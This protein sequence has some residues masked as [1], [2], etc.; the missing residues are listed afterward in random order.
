M[1]A[2]C[3][4]SST[5][6]FVYLNIMVRIVYTDGT[7][8]SDTLNARNRFLHAS[9]YTNLVATSC[10]Q[11]CRRR[12][13]QVQCTIMRTPVCATKEDKRISDTNVAS[14]AKK[15]DKMNAR[16]ITLPNLEVFLLSLADV[17][18]AKIPVAH[19]RC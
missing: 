7:D 6:R 9:E 17:E 3:S 11:V 16:R 18:Q 8:L 1:S 15:Y 2:A 5:V 4:P 10:I 12:K 14:T 13:A 19:N